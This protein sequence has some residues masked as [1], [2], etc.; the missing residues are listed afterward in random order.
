L[1]PLGQ[2]PRHQQAADVAV[3][4]GYRLPLRFPMFIMLWSYQWS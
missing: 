1:M 3:T 2:K 4:T